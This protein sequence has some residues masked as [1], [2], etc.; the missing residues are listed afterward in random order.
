ME[1]THDGPSGPQ[2]PSREQ[3]RLPPYSGDSTKD[4]DPT[5]SHYDPGATED[6][7]PSCFVFFRSQ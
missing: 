6:K 1:H 2:Q 7:P 4:N 5:P 3:F